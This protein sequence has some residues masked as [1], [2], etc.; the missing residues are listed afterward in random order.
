MKNMYHTVE[1]MLKENKLLRVRDFIQKGIPEYIVYDMVHQE[2]IIRE[3]RG[4]Y[5]LADEKLPKNYDLILTGL[6]VPNAVISTLSA[7]DYYQLTLEIP[8]EIHIALP[9]TARYPKITYPPIEVYRMSDASYS[10]GIVNL[11]LEGNMIKIYSAEK[12]ITDCF[13]FRKRLSKQVALDALKNYFQD[14]N[15]VDIKLLLKFARLNR[16]EKIMRPYLE[17]LL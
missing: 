4:I 13:K 16:V 7:L 5:R 9:R 14:R 11:N 6:S 15:N 8:G 17:S 2:K 1:K 12:T 10:A 3:S